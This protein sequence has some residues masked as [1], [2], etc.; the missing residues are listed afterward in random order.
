MQPQQQQQEQLGGGHMGMFGGQQHGGLHER[1]SAGPFADMGMQFS[2]AGS[3]Q[4]SLAGGTMDGQQD[5]PQQ[6]SYEPG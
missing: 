5:A 2:A 4:G 6:P 3:L 1:D